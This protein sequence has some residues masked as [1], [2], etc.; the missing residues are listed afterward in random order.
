M[1]ID[2]N[3]VIDRLT[4]RI[5]ELE[6]S[7]AILQVRAESLAEVLEEYAEDEKSDS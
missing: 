5:A 6:R 7:N 2:A 1:D 4:A 3:K